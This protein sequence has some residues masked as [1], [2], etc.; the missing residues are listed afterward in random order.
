MI[1][2]SPRED[3]LTTTPYDEIT[4]TEADGH[5]IGGRPL[6]EPCVA[7]GGE[8]DHPRCDVQVTPT[9]FVSWHHDC[10]FRAKGLVPAG[11]EFSCHPEQETNDGHTG[12]ALLHHLI[13]FHT[14]RVAAE[15][16]A[17]A[18]EPLDTKG[19]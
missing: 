10:H 7:C 4:W 1:T 16:A 5:N 18:A 19:D 2:D 8:D 13:D 14:A 6:R 3:M 15:E 9:E 11:Q 12:V 17:D